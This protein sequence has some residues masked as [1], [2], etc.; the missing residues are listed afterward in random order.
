MAVVNTL[1]MTICRPI[2]PSC[3]EPCPT[4]GPVLVCGQKRQ[5]GDTALAAKQDKSTA[6]YSTAQHSTCINSAGA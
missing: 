3:H 1:A 4:G 6:Q 2:T 5:E